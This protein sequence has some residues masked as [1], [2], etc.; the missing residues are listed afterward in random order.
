MLFSF[1]ARCHGL[2]GSQKYTCTPFHLRAE[3]GTNG[4]LRRLRSPRSYVCLVVGAPGAILH[5][6]SARGNVARYGRRR[7]AQRAAII[8]QELPARSPREISSRSGSDSRN[9]DCGFV[10]GLSPPVFSSR[11]CTDF[12]EHPTP[13]PPR[14]ASH[15]L[16]HGP[17]AP[18]APRVLAYA[19]VLIPDPFDTPHQTMIRMINRQAR[20]RDPLKPPVQ[21]P[22][23]AAAPV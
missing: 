15:L 20:C 21:V 13:L 12:A 11:R 23:S 1:V 14:G 6:G 7:S 4:Q 16:E 9:A 17:E 22:S 18:S 19:P 2:R 10:R 3:P 5:P 8:R